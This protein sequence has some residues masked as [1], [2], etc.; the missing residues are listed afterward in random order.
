[1][2][3]DVTRKGQNRGKGCVC[4]LRNWVEGAGC[5]DARKLVE[6]AGHDFPGM[7][8]GKTLIL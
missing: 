5:V 2:Q 3:N 4:M 1:M 8:L 7:W 6:H